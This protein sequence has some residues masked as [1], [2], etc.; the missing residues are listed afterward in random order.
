MHVS[1][2]INI[3]TVK[4]IMKSFQQTT[5]RNDLKK[6]DVNCATHCREPYESK[7]ECE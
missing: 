4:L 2:E 5:W 6:I 3:S 1:R 7:E